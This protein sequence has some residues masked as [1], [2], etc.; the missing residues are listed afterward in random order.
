MVQKPFNHGPLGPLTEKKP[1][2]VA[3]AYIGQHFG[4][5]DNLIPRQHAIFD[6]IRDFLKAPFSSYFG[7]AVC[8]YGLYVSISWARV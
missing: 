8:Q 2:V 7:A 1:V 4:V 3:P 6:K 5:K